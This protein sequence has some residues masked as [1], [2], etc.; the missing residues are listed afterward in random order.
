VKAPYKRIHVIINPAACGNEP[1]LNVLND[2]F[3]QHQVE[4]DVSITHRASDAVRQA[5]EAIEG[6]A[7]LVAGYGG[8]G[9][10]MVVTT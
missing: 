3:R 1:I 10:Q 9:T 2:V 7:D 4:W 6:G 5:Q 8:D